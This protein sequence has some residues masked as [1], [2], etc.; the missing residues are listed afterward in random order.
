MKYGLTMNVDPSQQIEQAI[1]ALK[2]LRNDDFAVACLIAC[3]DQAISAL[4]AVLFQREPSGLYQPR[5]R[6]V[7]VL[8]SLGAHDVL[9]EFLKVQRNIADLV[10][11]VG[12]DVVI[13]A[14]AL[15]LARAPTN[16]RDE[17]LFELL[18]R[19]ANRPC[20]TGVIGALGA[21]RRVEAIPVLIN[22]LEEDASRFTAEGALRKLGELARAALFDTVDRR[23]PS[24][25]RESESSARRRRSALRMLAEM[26][27]APEEWPSLRP[28]MHDNDARVAVL[29]CKICLDRAPVEERLV[30]ARCLLDLLMHDD[31]MLREEIENALVAHFGNARDAIDRFF[32]EARPSDGRAG[33]RQQI[34]D[35]LRRVMGGQE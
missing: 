35:V 32:N 19:L 31:W 4:R 18:L 8:A 27:V 34:E 6:V 15:A 14:T 7:E 9:I 28:L 33:T 3:G 25:E 10:E 1:A 11:R 16:T 22:A 13:S 30:A 24:R 26:G 21:Y 20:L 5:R 17:R 12:E 23:L 29:A 2:T